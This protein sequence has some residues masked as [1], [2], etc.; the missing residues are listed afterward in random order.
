MAVVCNDLKIHYRKLFKKKNHFKVSSKDI[1]TLF[2]Y[3]P[4]PFYCYFFFFFLTERET[5]IFKNA[6]CPMGER[7]SE[8]GIH[9]R[10]LVHFSSLKWRCTTNQPVYSSYKTI[11]SFPL[12]Y[13]NHHLLDQLNSPICLFLSLINNDH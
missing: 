8:P 10:N 12:V 1:H 6:I 7:E 3:L 2:I 4:F 11:L 13:V 9:S 5:V